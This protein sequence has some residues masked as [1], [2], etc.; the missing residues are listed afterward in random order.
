MNESTIPEIAPPFVHRREELMR[1]IGPRAV[2]VVHGSRP[3][4]RNR[5]VEHRY[6]APS[7]LLFLTGFDEPETWLVITPGRDEKFTMFVR[8]RD[9]EQETWTG[10]RLGVE[11]ATAKLGADKAHPVTELAAKLPDLLDGAD[12][13]HYVPGDDPEVD[14]TIMDAVNTLRRGERRGRRAPV[15]FIDLVGTLHEIRLIKD[16]YALARLRRAVEITAEAHTLAMRAARPGTHEY[17]IEA[18]LDYTFR[19]RGAG[20]PGYGTI[21][22]GGENATILHYTE[23]R[24]PLRA[25]ELLLV[26]AGAEVDGFTADVTRTY[27]IGARF[28]EAQRRVYEV[29]L[30]AEK[31]CI[32]MGRPGVSIDEI[33]ARAIELLTEGMVRLGLLDGEVP[34]LIK[35]EAYKRFYMHR[36]SHWL[37]LDVH[38]VGRYAPEG[39]SRPLEAGMVLTVEPGLYI[40]AAT[41]PEHKLVPPE[42]IGIGVRIEDDVLVTPDGHEVLTRA[43]P[44]EIDELEALATA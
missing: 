33:H 43:I 39:R 9:P 20:G 18:L 11:G 19:R 12:E 4:R 7:D 26:D 44:K 8:P 16:A 13:V 27:P 23:N 24:D 15:R 25:G 3:A 38:D 40:T 5:D 31:A 17:E 29:V 2:A 37:G 32:A 28:T 6:R 35:S 42:F 41:K 10:R 22:G 14:R 21:A 1:R 34:D 30:A 36:T